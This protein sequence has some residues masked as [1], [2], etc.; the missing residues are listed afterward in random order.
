MFGVAPPTAN[1]NIASA[2]TAQQPVVSLENFGSPDQANSVV[3]NLLSSTANNAANSSIVFE[4]IA[5]QQQQL[6]QQIEMKPSDNIYVKG[7]PPIMAE[8]DLMR[9]FSKASIVKA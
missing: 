7:L 1:I 2:S 8:N 6:M 3:N 4:A 9:L 5:Q